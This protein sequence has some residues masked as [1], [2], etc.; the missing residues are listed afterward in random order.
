MEPSDSLV[1]RARK[2]L[3]V[4]LLSFRSVWE[5][6]TQAQQMTATRRKIALS[7]MLTVTKKD[8]GDNATPEASTRNYLDGLL[9]LV[10]AYA[11]AGATKLFTAPAEEERTT[12]AIEV[13]ECPLDVVYKYYFRCVR[14][15]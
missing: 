11:R 15:V 10:L 9:T 14:Q 12:P 2:E 13:V 7:K 3:R 1:S 8:E 6:H 5:V 4:R